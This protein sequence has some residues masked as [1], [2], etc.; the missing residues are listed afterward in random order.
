MNRVPGLTNIYDIDSKIH[1]FVMDL[2]VIEKHRQAMREISKQ[3][4]N[5]GV[6]IDMDSLYNIHIHH[7][8]LYYVKHIHIIIDDEIVN[9]DST[10]GICFGCGNICTDS[11]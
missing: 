8:Y 11:T 3:I 1:D 6:W 10:S 4:E 5:V 2:V 9:L 7:G